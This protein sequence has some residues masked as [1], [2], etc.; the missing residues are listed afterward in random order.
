MQPKHLTWL[1]WAPLRVLKKILKA[2]AHATGGLGPNELGSE[3]DTDEG[4]KAFLAQ[5][6]MYYKKHGKEP[7]HLWDEATQKYLINPK[8][9]EI[10]LT[11]L[12]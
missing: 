9:R 3:A 12:Q 11:A 7:L 2:L 10:V 5:L 4:T 1:G 6:T 8:Y